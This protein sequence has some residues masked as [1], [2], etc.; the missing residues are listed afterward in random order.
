MHGI[1]NSLAPDKSPGSDGF[2]GCFF[3]EY[4]LVMKT[5]IINLVS[6]F[7]NGRGLLEHINVIFVTLIPKFNGAFS[8]CDF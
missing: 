1:V 8:I 3:K 5:E 6:Y 7:F 4:W 2:T